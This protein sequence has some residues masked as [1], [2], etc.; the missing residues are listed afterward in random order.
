MGPITG[1]GERK[2]GYW[3][4]VVAACAGVFAVAY[5]TTAVMT[6]LPAIKSSL[7][8]SVDTLQW[9]INI[10]MLSTAVTLAAMGHFGDTF[11]L[12]RMFA[13]GLGLFA[14]GSITLALSGDA[15]VLLAGRSVQGL[16]VAALM[17]T[18]VAL[19]S[20]SSPPE[21][22]ASMHGAWAAAVA[23]GFALGPL[24]GGTIID[25]ISWRA[26]FVL[27]LLILG[28]AGFLCFRVD[29]LDLVP[30][31]P[32][33]GKHTDFGGIALLFVMLASF[34]YGL[35][36]GQLSGWLAPQTLML[37]GFAIAG[38]VGFVIRELHADDPLIEF[39]FFRHLDYVAATICMFLN[40]I[41]QMGV[42]YFTNI[43]LQSPTGLDFSASQAGLALL[44]F[45]I[46]MFV[47]SLTLPRLI[48][49][50]RYRIPVIL[51]MLLLAV[52]Y[53]LMHDID[54]QTPY[55][56]IWWRLAIMGVG[57]GF[58]WALLP[59]LGLGALPDAHAG[60]GSGV[61]NT[62][63]F[64]GLA[65]GTA[66][67]GVVAS[68]IKHDVIGPVVD[69]IAAST[70]HLH[71]LKIM[72]VHGSESQIQRAM[73]KIPHA[74]VSKLETAMLGAADSGFS[75]VMIFMMITALLGA[76][77]GAL[78]IRPEKKTP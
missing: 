14:L 77:V 5:N 58:N 71:T 60:Q 62:T 4:V 41:T 9:V 8:L 45:T 63:M 55:S 11:G 22:R 34:L 26:I 43:F 42:L 76:V 7:D 18:S 24:I 57:V 39:G 59:R 23:V 33:A 30:H 20:V 48:A 2:D 37:F 29:R 15:V 66:L 51:G 19:I 28:V 13:V 50:G 49:T 36:S 6:A 46:A 40:G 44:P 73:T 17:A 68:R 32:D 21:K 67:G 56:D 16:G 3:L 54:H 69:S 64:A 35:T 27:D 1:T 53:W 61:L 31:Q 74:D 70:P 78:F 72:L 65:T 52:S 10:Y 25:V 38:G 47:V 75:G 12:A